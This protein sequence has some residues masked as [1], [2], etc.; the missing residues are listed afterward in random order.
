M[1][2]PAKVTDNPHL[3]LYKPAAKRAYLGCGIKLLHQSR[4]ARLGE[5]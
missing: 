3:D 4:P 5:Y 1:F 2:I